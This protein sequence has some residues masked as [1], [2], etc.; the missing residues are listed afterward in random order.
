MNNDPTSY[1]ESVREYIKYLSDIS[2]RNSE[3]LDY[4]SDQVTKAEFD[5]LN[6]SELISECENLAKALD[7]TIKMSEKIA[8]EV[9]RLFH[10]DIKRDTLIN[11]ILKNEN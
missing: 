10:K 8:Q 5:E 4:I 11:T 7:S 6:G 1:R 2:K 9:D 3:Y